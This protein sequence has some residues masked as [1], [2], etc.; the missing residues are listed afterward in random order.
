MDKMEVLKGLLGE[1]VA[2]EFLS[3][4]EMNGLSVSAEKTSAGVSLHFSGKHAPEYGILTESLPSDRRKCVE[5]LLD[6]MFPRKK[7]NID[8]FVDLATVLKL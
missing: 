7:V 5:A 2:T 1:P 6:F 8:D 3:V 4:A